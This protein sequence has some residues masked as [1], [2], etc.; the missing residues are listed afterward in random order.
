MKDDHRYCSPCGA[1]IPISQMSTQDIL[2]CLRDGI[3]ASEPGIAWVYLRLEIEL[4][5]RKNQL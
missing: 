4:I 5:I 3:K 1:M 2:G